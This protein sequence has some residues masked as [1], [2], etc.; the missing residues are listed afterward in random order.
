MLLYEDKV[1]RLHIVSCMSLPTLLT[2]PMAGGTTAL[3]VGNCHNSPNQKQLSQNDPPPV[4]PHTVTED[5]SCMMAKPFDFGPSD[6][7]SETY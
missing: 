5:L 3:L 7:A 2:L 6:P 4:G 1:A